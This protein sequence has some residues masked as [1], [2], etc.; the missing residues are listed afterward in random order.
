M[1]ENEIEKTKLPENPTLEDEDDSKVMCAD[2]PEPKDYYYIIRSAQDAGRLLNS[3]FTRS[4]DANDK[5]WTGITHLMGKCIA[6]GIRLGRQSLIDAGWI[7]PESISEPT[8]QEIRDVIFQEIDSTLERVLAHP[9]N[10]PQIRRIAVESMLGAVDNYAHWSSVWCD[11]C[12]GEGTIS[13]RGIQADVDIMD[14]PICKGTGFKTQHSKSPEPITDEKLKERIAKE[15]ID[16]IGRSLPDDCS[17]CHWNEPD[18]IHGACCSY[19]DNGICADMVRCPQDWDF[20]LNKASQILTLIRE[21]GYGKVAE[22]RPKIVCLCGSTRFVDTF[23]IYRQKLTLEGKIVLSIEIVTT[24]EQKDDPQYCNPQL[25]QMLDE[26]HKRK[27][28]LADEVFVLNVG[29]YIG[30]STRSEIEYAKAHGKPI[31]YLE[32]LKEGKQ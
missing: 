8:K 9:M 22:G 26:L 30:E 21:A 3:D 6:R 18:E 7:K 11:N 16:D 28:D 27:I 17:D 5:A 32:A 29:G 12:D 1:S 4:K 19:K 25:K 2:M 24:Q 14:C 15:L 20:C 10:L 31:R 23:N 13:A